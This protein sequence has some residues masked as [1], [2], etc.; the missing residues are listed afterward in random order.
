MR[1]PLRYCL[2]NIARRKTRTALTVLGI[3]FVVGICTVMFAFARGVTESLRGSGSPDNIIVID[4]RAAN[5]TF[6]SLDAGD[7]ARLKG[8]TEV[9]RSQDGEPLMS[10][11]VLHQVRIEAGGQKELPGTVRGA[12]QMILKVNRHIRLEEGVT[13][14]PGR[15][16]I[17]GN[18]AHAA[19]GVPKEAL[20]VGK[21]VK[22]EQFEWTIV[23]RF[24]A[25]KTAVE[26]LFIADLSDM[27]AAFKRTKYSSVT[28]QA[29]DPSIV[30]AAV[31]RLNAKTD[32]KVKAFTEEAY[33]GEMAS[34]TQRIV[35]LAFAMAVIATIGGLV[36]GMNTMY[37]AVMGRIRE[38]G[39]L[40]VQGF[41]AGD[42]LAAVLVESLLIAGLGALIGCAL[43]TLVNGL[44]VK[45]SAGAAAMI[46]D[47]QAIIGG[48]LVAVVVGV[49]G[50]L[51]PGIK[52]VRMK[53]V[54][55]LRHGG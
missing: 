54:D 6:S 55:A 41:G 14:G 29:A 18:L 10:P 38:I 4:K 1:I 25:G 49:V 3:G 5:E 20:A 21:T 47:E 13:F 35:M 43:A 9:R 27:L 17:V 48:T 12:T 53:I 19:L 23:G 51:P 26:S 11:E 39:T 44:T 46:V 31:A 7:V 37:A 33:Y 15:N 36:S 50:A 30:E 42:I 22:F 16:I 32:I 40:K 34:G 28:F 45:V 8:F 24:T 2:R 52:G